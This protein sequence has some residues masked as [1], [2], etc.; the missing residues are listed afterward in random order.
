MAKKDKKKTPLG[1]VGRVERERRY[2]RGII[3]GITLVISAVIVV[4]IVGVVLE[5]AIRPEQP[6]A[7][8]SGDEILTKDFQA[9]VRF[10]R[11]QLVSQYLNIYQYLQ[12]L[13]FD[14]ATV[15]QYQP[16]LQQIQLQLDPV[17]LGNNVLDRMINGVI[18]KQEAA[19]RGIEV[20]DDE[21]NSYFESMFGYF[22]NGT[23]TP[24]PTLEIAPTST[25]SATQLALVTLTPTPT[26]T[27]TLTPN[28]EASLTPQPSPTND[29]PTPTPTLY[30]FSEYQTDL[31]TYFNNLHNE[32]KISEEDMRKIISTEILRG[33]LSE[34]ITKDM[35]P[36]Q[37]Q[38]WARHILV[39]DEETALEVIDRLKNGEDWSALALEYSQDTSNASRGG[40]LGWFSSSRMVPEFSQAAIDTPIGEISDPVETQYGWH[41]IQVLGHEIRPL[42]SNEFNQLKQ[43]EFNNWLS[44]VRLTVDI[45]IKDYWSKRIPKEPA[46]PQQYLISQ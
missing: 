31:T 11:G 6:V 1:K 14:S 45:E 46:I 8:V 29:V 20:S 25:L 24:E 15:S 41:I 13:N 38:V 26:S 12:L 23:P 18:I 44:E 4:I 33:K 5:G 9:R 3:I 36:E 2:N 43:T 42:S 19:A 34:E 21:I 39:A 10:E 40:D 37:E 22:P 27:P 7:I 30:T 35:K 17:A 32:I 16:Y 28:P